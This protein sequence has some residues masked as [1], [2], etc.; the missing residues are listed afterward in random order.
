MSDS[1]YEPAEM[2]TRHWISSLLILFFIMTSILGCHRN[3]KNVITPSLRLAYKIRLGD[4][5][6]YARA[7]HYTD[8]FVKFSPD[9]RYL[10][11]GTFLGKIILVNAH[12]GHLLWDR[13]VPEAMVKKIAF[14]RDSKTIYYGEQG[15]DGNI[16]AADTKTGRLRW[17]FSMSKSLKRGIPASKGDIYGIYQE[18]GCYRIKVLK[19]GNI[20]VLGIHSWADRKA[21]CWQ[22]LS[23]IWLLTPGGRVI[24]KWP[25]KQPIRFSLV[26][27]D[28]DPTGRYIV[29]VATLP[30]DRLPP[31]YPY[32][33]GTVYILDGKSGKEISSYTIPPLTPYYHSVSIWESVAVDPK[34]KFAVVG[35]SDGRGY[36]FRLPELVPVKILDLGTPVM[37][38]DLPVAATCTYVHVTSNTIFFQTGRSSIPYGMPLQA[39]QPAG[40]HP[41]AE[42]IFA[43][44]PGGKI[45]WR[46]HAAFRFQGFASDPEG[47]ILATVA[48]ASGMGRRTRGNQFGLF[49]FDL[50][51]HGG[52]MKKLLGY[53]PSVAPLFFHLAV[54]PDAHLIAICE[55][56]Y[57][58]RK[59]EL[60]G[61]Y[62]INVIKI[63]RHKD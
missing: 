61:S 30:S 48:G 8:A 63:Y 58:N 31:H 40:P 2:N 14:S 41:N 53:Y 44:S 11:V 19:D 23:R 6:F 49:V 13:T 34:D 52:G 51:R 33:P 29:A 35:T 46:F 42:T 20:L 39:N 50:K 38:G 18:P 26:Y 16:Y 45:L 28:S 55:T 10:A 7:G 4:V 59:G 17:Q 47:R 12:S 21:G 15:P 5:S 9:G 1:I 60:T 43:V 54:S 36:I 25:E 22:R 27:A 3:N 37:V 24:W 56:P 57:L 32:K 62:E